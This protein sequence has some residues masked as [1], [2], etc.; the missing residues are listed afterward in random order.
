MVDLV[1]RFGISALFVGNFTVKMT[2]TCRATVLSSFPKHTKAVMCLRENLHV[3]DTLPSGMQCAI[4][5][6][7]NA[8]ESTIYI[9]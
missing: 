3:L 8:N 4:G 1:P 9:K 6:E 2:P 7:F 5:H